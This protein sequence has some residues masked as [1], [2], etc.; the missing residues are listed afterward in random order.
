MLRSNEIL[1]MTQRKICIYAL[2]YFARVESPVLCDKLHFFQSGNHW[3]TFMHHTLAA[4]A[5]LTEVVVKTVVM[6]VAVI[7]LIVYNESRSYWIWSL[8][9]TLFWPQLL[10]WRQ[11]AKGIWGGWEREGGRVMVRGTQRGMCGKINV[12]ERQKRRGRASNE[13]DGEWKVYREE[14]R[15]GRSKDKWVEE[16]EMGVSGR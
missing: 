4:A 10:K 7:T 8:R 3:F 6:P 9:L 12:T 15:H 13:C 14:E 1:I 5:F 16:V 11:W 2:T